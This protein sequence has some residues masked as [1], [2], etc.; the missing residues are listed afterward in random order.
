MPA[1]FAETLTASGR[2]NL[3]NPAQA[4]RRSVG[5]AS[6]TYTASRSDATI[7]IISAPTC[8]IPDSTTASKRLNLNDVANVERKESSLT[9]PRPSTVSEKLGTRSVVCTESIHLSMPE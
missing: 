1:Y 4:D 3:N 8:C 7:A 5:A 6:Q 2:L 9:L